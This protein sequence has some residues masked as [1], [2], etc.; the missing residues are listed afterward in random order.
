M[1]PFQLLEALDE[2]CR[3][4]AAGLP[5]QDD[6][7]EEW[8]GIGFR[9]GDQDLL[10]PM[11]E[12]TEILT[13]A[14]YTRVPGV[15]EWIVGLANVRGNLVSV[16]DLRQLITGQRVHSRRDARMLVM[17]NDG[18]SS[19]MQ[20]DEV[21]GLKHFFVE[22]ETR[23]LPKLDDSIQPYVTQAFVRDGQYWPVFSVKKLARD[24]QFD[25]VAL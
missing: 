23:F 14:E 13:Y 21:L 11:S 15:K 1:H 10:V 4:H 16:I 12:V 2:R 19:A 8:V 3:T 6:V 18:W 20:V 24:Q 17:Q 9:L 22:E 25:Q 5:E 7:K